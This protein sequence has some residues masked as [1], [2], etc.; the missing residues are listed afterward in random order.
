MMTST[1]LLFPESFKRTEN[2]TAVLLVRKIFFQRSLVD[3]DL[4]RAIANAYSSH[5]RFSPPRAQGV[6]V[7]LIFASCNHFSSFREDLLA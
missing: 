5:G 6:I 1:S 2:A 3:Q 7:E 4:S